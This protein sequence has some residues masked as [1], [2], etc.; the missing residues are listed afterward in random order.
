MLSDFAGLYFGAAA[1][2]W[3]GGLLATGCLMA[4]VAMLAGVVE[5]TRVPEGPALRDAW[6]HMGAMLV[7]LVLFA[8]RL[9]LR[10][11]HRKALAPDLVSLLLDAGGFVAL[12]VGGWF[13]GRLVYQ[14]GIGRS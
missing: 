3:S 2:S 14:H 11:D 10:L 7:A 9:L 12:A 4:I 13:G 5:L 1:W 8:T 6:W